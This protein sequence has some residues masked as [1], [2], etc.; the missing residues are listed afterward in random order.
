VNKF[1]T[2]VSEKAGGVLLGAARAAP[3]LIKYPLLVGNGA[4]QGL[5]LI[6]PQQR[7]DNAKL[8]EEVF[9]PRNYLSEGLQNYG[10]HLEKNQPGSIR[11]GEVGAGA[12]VG[13][14]VGKTVT[15]ILP[16]FLAKETVQKVSYPVGSAVVGA[17]TNEFGESVVDTAEAS[18]EKTISPEEYA[19]QASYLKGLFE[20]PTN[21]DKNFIQRIMYPQ[22][23][24]VLENED[25]SVS[26]HSMA[27]GEVD[28]KQ[29]VFPTVIQTEDGGLQR[30]EDESA[31]DHALRTG[32]FLEFDT[33]EEAGWVSENYKLLWQ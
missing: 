10:G 16:N 28:G 17:L 15:N 30:L 19:K 31:L 6:T 27:W 23:F 21:K 3:N 20:D 4:A 7:V 22:Y 13:G 5:G 11:A 12:Y 24:P 29:V 32:E 9:N 18:A 1:L 25:G 8:Y 14:L 26:T 33:P 2:D